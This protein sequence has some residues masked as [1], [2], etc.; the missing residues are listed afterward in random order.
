LHC[1]L[2]LELLYMKI[3]VLYCQFK[4][5]REKATRLIYSIPE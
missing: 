1:D 3:K 5:S 4:S 2:S